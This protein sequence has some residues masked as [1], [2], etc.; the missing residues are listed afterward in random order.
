MLGTLGGAASSELKSGVTIVGIGSYSV[1]QIQKKPALI[2]E[3]QEKEKENPI[4]VQLED[5]SIISI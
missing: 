2:A 1:D 3:I 5:K 4:N